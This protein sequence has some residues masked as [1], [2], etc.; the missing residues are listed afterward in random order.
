MSSS[1]GDDAANVVVVSMD[2]QDTPIN[3][4]KAK[5][6]RNRKKKKFYCKSLVKAWVRFNFCKWKIF[7]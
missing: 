6:K 2:G 3:A 7:R 4:G 5:K 1:V